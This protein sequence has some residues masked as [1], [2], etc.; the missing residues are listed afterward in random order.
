MKRPPAVTDLI[1]ELKRMPGIGQK[2]AERLSFFVM[3]GSNERANKLADA[4]RN[5][6]EKIILC[7]QCHGITEI[8][9]CE[10]CRDPKRDPSIVCVVEEPHDVYAMEN[11]GHFRGVYHVLMGVI[12]PLDGI[13]PSELTIEAL[14]ERVM[15]DN[16]Q[17]VVLATNPDMEGE[18]TAVYIAKIL[19]PANIK[20]TR[21]ARG[22]PVGGDIEYADEVTLLKSLEGRTE[23]N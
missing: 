5:I 8:N 23:M 3:R 10:I 21:I 18:S 6:K 4:V 2:T 14:K 17:E 12:S 13:G 20:V 19:K 16:I 7:S 11:M 1:E 9:P 22:L 15:K